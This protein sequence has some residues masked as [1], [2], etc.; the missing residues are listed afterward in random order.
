MKR[1]PCSQHFRT[2]FIFDGLRSADRLSQF[3]RLSVA[4]GARLSLRVRKS[5]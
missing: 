1:P 3:E 4:N 5:F 2:R